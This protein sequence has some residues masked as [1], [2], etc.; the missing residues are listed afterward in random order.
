MAD[1]SPFAVTDHGKLTTFTSRVEGSGE[2]RLEHA[3]CVC[4]EPDFTLVEDVRIT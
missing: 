1:N 4:F 3:R 2:G